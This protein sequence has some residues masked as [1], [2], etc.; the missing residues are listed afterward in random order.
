[1]RLSGACRVARLPVVACVLFGGTA[2][3]AW[4]YGGTVPLPDVAGVTVDAPQV[5]IPTVVVPPTPDAALPAPA[6]K[7][8]APAPA[9]GDSTGDTIVIPPTTSSAESTPIAPAS[10]P[11]ATP[12]QTG[13]QHQ[14]EPARARTAAAP[15]ATAPDT[16]QYQ[17]ENASA[18][19][20]GDNTPQNQT[21]PVADNAPSSASE[22]P[23]TWTWNWNWNCGDA[24]AGAQQITPPAPDGAGPS[25]WIWNWTWDCGD[26]SGNTAISIRVLSPGDNGPVT[27]VIDSGADIA[28]AATDAVPAAPD[29]AAQPGTPSVASASESPPTLPALPSPERRY[30]YDAM[31][32][33]A[34]TKV[35]TDL[36]SARPAGAATRTAG[37]I[38][39]R[40]VASVPESIV[41]AADRLVAEAESPSP[42]PPPGLASTAV[43]V[44]AAVAA[45]GERAAGAVLPIELVQADPPRLSAPS[46]AR[47][48]REG[49][50]AVGLHWSPPE[51]SRSVA[52][53]VRARAQAPAAAPPRARAART[54]WPKIP[55]RA[56]VP[57]D[58]FGS[59]G[60]PE[61][62]PT[63]PSGLVLLVALLFALSLSAPGIARVVPVSHD[64]PRVRPHPRR[65]E[66][67]G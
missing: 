52:H 32:V 59:P 16:G 66:K 18:P 62:A 53:P 45:V 43:A 26:L 51:P 2:A 7:S 48:L 34:T 25:T 49:S 5:V 6:T 39:G 54:R 50:E 58:W 13:T 57:A 33:D 30:R 27:Q 19:A 1:M 64:R 23:S 24:S 29:A 21:I 44:A 56:P 41:P 15:T 22:H 11:T 42:P 9:N 17:S 12:S 20:H 65:P 38:V 31:A 67:P 10:T 37:P 55:L 61:R 36:M 3:P 46:V 60:S 47:R 28:A 14:P 35:L 8:T 40:A 4:A 63:A